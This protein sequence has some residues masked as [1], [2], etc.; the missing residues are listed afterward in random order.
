MVCL[1]GMKI[2]IN[3]DRNIEGDERLAE[4]VEEVVENAIGRFADQVTRVEVHLADV[5]AGKRGEDDK[6]CMMEGRISGRSPMAVTH[7][8]GTLRDAIRGA[9]DKL[10]RAI[11]REFG[12]LSAR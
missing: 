7:H 6:R 12:K 8:A 1:G 9:A 11:E 3:T 10:E 5:N 4:Y 2:Q